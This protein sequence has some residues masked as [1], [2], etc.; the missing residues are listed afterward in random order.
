MKIPVNLIPGF[1]EST[2]PVVVLRNE[3]GS[4]KAGF[5]MR[6]SEFIASVSLLSDGYKSAGIAEPPETIVESLRT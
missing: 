4:F 5:V 1:Y 2:R 3:D 6:S